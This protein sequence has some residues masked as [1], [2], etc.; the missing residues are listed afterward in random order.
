[1]V[2]FNQK[3]S[4]KLSWAFLFLFNNH[5]NFLQIKEALCKE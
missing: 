2:N 3:E 1:M 4:Q 5:K